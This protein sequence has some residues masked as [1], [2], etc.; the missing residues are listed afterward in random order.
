M[1]CPVCGVDNDKVIDSRTGAEGV[2]IRRRRQCLSCNRRYTTYERV[3]EIEIKVVKKDGTR[4]EFKPDKIRRG[5]ET[6]CWK[7]PVSNEQLETLIARIEQDIYSNHEDE[8]GSLDLGQIVMDHLRE[9]DQVAYIRFAS[10]Y[11]SF[12]DAHDFV[13]EVQPMLKPKS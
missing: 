10:V 6:A 11:R 2:V 4:E 12:E 5:L 3:G 8:I 7:R 13:T 1:K 9:L